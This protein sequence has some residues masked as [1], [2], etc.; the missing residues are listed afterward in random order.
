ML[1]DWGVRKVLD[2]T[3]EKEKWRKKKEKFQIKTLK[4]FP[5]LY[6]LFRERTTWWIVILQSQGDTNKV[7]EEAP[8]LD[9]L[10]LSP[11][12]SL[13]SSYLQWFPSFDGMGI[14]ELEIYCKPGKFHIRQT[15]KINHLRQIILINPPFCW[16]TPSPFFPLVVGQSQLFLT[17]S[18]SPPSSSPSPP[19]WWCLFS[20]FWFH[21]TISTK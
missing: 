19:W 18:S 9:S 13:S 11:S 6:E 17:Q 7:E 10:S 21:L 12:S 3:W 8:H 4:S 15:N 16:N 14:R 1:A 2:N 5:S 20:S